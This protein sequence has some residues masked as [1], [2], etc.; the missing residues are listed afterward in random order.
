MEMISAEHSTV[1]GVVALVYRLV[2]VRGIRPRWPLFYRM[3][4]VVGLV[5]FGTGRSGQAAVPEHG[6]GDVGAWGVQ[7]C[8]SYAL[9]HHLRIENAQLDVARTAEEAYAT[10]GVYDPRIQLTG[11]FLDSELPESQ[12]FVGTGTERASMMGRLSQRLD[13]GTTLSLEAEASRFTFGDGASGTAPPGVDVPRADP[14][15]RFSLTLGLQQPL[16]RNARGRLDRTRTKVSEVAFKVA[17]HR[18]EQARAQLAREVYQ[19]Y[20]DAYVAAQLH[21]VELNGLERSKRLLRIN[22]AHVRDGLLDRVDVLAVEAA[23]ATRE[24]DVL[25]RAHEVEQH[26]DA[27]KDVVGF[28]RGVWARTQIHFDRVDPLLSSVQAPDFLSA[29]ETALYAR[30]D[31]RALRRQRQQSLTRIE[32]RVEEAKPELTM[33][34]RISQG[35]AADASF[36]GS[37]GFGRSAWFLGVSFE[38]PWRRRAERSA[39]RQ[40]RVA[41]VQVDNQLQLLAREVEL[42]CRWAVRRLAT[43]EKQVWATQKA[44]MLHQEKLNV[45]LEKQRQG[46]SSTSI[47]ISYQDD[48]GAAEARCVEAL[49]EYQQALAQYRFAIGTILDG[50]GRA[51]MGRI[52]GGG[53]GKQVPRTGSK[54]PPGI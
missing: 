18:L 19:R 5:F 20:W 15:S 51:E 1:V 16:L 21:D 30:W 2:W 54:Q 43:A 9:T 23:I 24:V 41:L 42:D 39:V 40:A 45:E 25:R 8:V 28:P 12:A 35:D 37:F 13:S 10:L 34:G 6:Q 3:S 36:D 49:G 7:A 52:R 31:I 22:Q 26:A 4:A 47:V 17:R 46:R 53:E 11:E 48:L 32:L 50:Y 38:M 29:Y 14:V 27:L 44:R 33:T